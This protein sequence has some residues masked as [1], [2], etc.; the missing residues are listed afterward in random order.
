M[1]ILTV[2]MRSGLLTINDGKLHMDIRV[3]DGNE[4]AKTLFQK[5]TDPLVSSY[6]VASLPDALELLRSFA[7]RESEE[8]KAVYELVN[9]N[10]EP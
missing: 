9:A 7:D 10:L 3:A 6:K 8:V 5:L 1:M 4:I 2:L